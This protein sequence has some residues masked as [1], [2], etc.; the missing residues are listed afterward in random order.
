M[1]WGRAHSRAFT[2][3]EVVI[4]VALIALLAGL[5]MSAVQ[6]AR[7]SAARVDCQN[8]LR[9]IGLALH[10]YHDGT[11]HLPA[12]VRGDRPSEPL[13]F[14]SWCVSILPYL[15][16]EVLW[17]EIIAAFASDKD[18]LHSPP[19]VHVKTPIRRFAC[20]LDERVR[21]ARPTGS[22]HKV[23]AFTSFLGVEGANAFRHD[24]VFFL[25]S[26]TRLEDIYDGTSHTL[27]VGERPPSADLVLG[28]WYA[29]WGQDKDGEGDMLLGTRTRNHSEYGRGCPAGPYDF[30]PGKFDNQCDAFHFWSPHSGGANFLLC[31]GSVRFL[32]YSA[33]PILPALASRAGGEAAAVP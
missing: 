14:S 11:G 6:K 8:N 21:T 12:G 17:G 4:V 18:F 20:P 22:D 9:Q 24:G 29:G 31:D 26:Q 33:N 3:V 16:Q 25:D 7:L 2:L 10:S 13:P 23:R 5:T 19:H 1:R 30:Q 27:A 28:W 32:P 15:E